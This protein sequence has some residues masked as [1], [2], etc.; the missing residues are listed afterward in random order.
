MEAATTLRPATVTPLGNRLVVDGLV[1]DDQRAVELV[2]GSEDP[3]ATLLRTIET[4]ARVL[5]REQAGATVELFR[6]DLEKSTR[7]AEA[8]LQ[9]RAHE[10]AD[11]FAKRFDEAFGTEGQLTR[12]LQRLFGDESAVAVQHRIKATL[13]EVNRQGRDQ[14]VRQFS[15]PD[16]SNPLADFKAGVL[17]V[18]KQQV[19]EL[20]S[21]REQVVELRAEVQRLHAEKEKAS[22]VAA[23]HDR[24]TAKG[25]PYE[26]AVFDAVEAIAGGHGDLAEAV[27]DEAG[28]GGRKGDVVVGLDGCDG[29]PRAR[30]VIEAKHS[31]TSRKAA[32][33]YLDEAMQQRD[34]AYGIWVVPSDAALP[35]KT[36]E[37][38]PVNGDKLFVVYD[39][40]EG[41][42][43]ALQVAYSL[44][45]ASVLLSRGDAEGLDG[46]ALR[47]EVERA[48]MV[49]DD[50][51]RV[52][53]QLTSANNGIEAARK[54]VESMAAVVRGHLQEIDRMV[55]E[56]DGDEDGPRQQS[57][58]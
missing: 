8:A 55:A 23:E 46:A 13:E 48:L 56:A 20:V 21:M 35:A 14:L 53:A 40:E 2:R 24:S 12:E 49:L 10:L 9:Q 38:R 16:A 47:V 36:V 28:T 51:R 34:A 15:S 42:R 29:P 19:T 4:G 11:G 17:N 37:L 54:I 52:K 32:L 31:Q 41:S 30:I 1:V 3:V 25:R 58:V 6:A 22:E 7:E 39:P 26:E 5:D 44:A 43:S 27:G 18:T 57:L 45:R 50:E 33:Q